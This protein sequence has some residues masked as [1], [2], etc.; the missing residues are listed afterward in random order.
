[1]TEERG[2]GISYQEKIWGRENLGEKNNMIEIR[3][4]KRGER[5]RLWEKIRRERESGCGWK[6][7]V[8][9]KEIEIKWKKSGSLLRRG[10]KKT[11]IN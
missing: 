8:W 5:K 9:K 1:M 10:E 4:E 11:N 3:R 2:G 6:E 7:L